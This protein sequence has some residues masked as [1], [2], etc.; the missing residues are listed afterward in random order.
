VKI[1]FPDMREMVTG[2]G[3]GL[4][5]LMGG[6]LLLCSGLF[7]TKV[8]LSD[9]VKVADA[10]IRCHISVYNQG[11]ANP[12]IH[13][14]FWE[15]QCDLCHLASGSQWAENTGSAELDKVTGTV[16]TQELLWRKPQLFSSQV[17]ASFDHLVGLSGLAAETAYRFR[18]Q[19]RFASAA[20]DDN[21]LNGQWIGLRPS[22][23]SD[24]ITVPLPVDTLILGGDAG[25]I[26][27]ASLYWDGSTVFVTLQTSQLV[28]TQI[29]VQDLD[30]LSLNA[31]QITS[32]ESESVSAQEQHPPMKSAEALA[33]EAC[34]QCHSEADLGTSHPVRLYGGKD[35]HIPNE[36]PTVD[37]MLTCITCHNPHGSEGEMLVREMIKTKL[38]VTC[39]YKFKNS[40]PSTMFQ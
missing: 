8:S 13:A 7:F 39:H 5:I 36:L 26:K 23:L 15:R 6:V 4:I 32:S 16:V 30:G 37:G 10:C 21:D 31:E 33:I 12:V 19:L 18:I 24:N 40:S 17:D 29:E 28:T 34:Y 35:V 14:P 1:D 38:C 2:R 11:L 20:L 3:G 27:T 25:L 22:E 9:Q